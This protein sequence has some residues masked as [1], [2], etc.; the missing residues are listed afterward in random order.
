M[1]FHEYKMH[2][3]IH[4]ETN[5]FKE[6]ALEKECIQLVHHGKDLNQKS[7]KITAYGHTY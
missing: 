1:N 4:F 5:M 3:C 2:I 7:I 6:R